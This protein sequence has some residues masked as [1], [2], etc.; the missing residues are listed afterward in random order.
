MTTN[1]LTI[2]PCT[3]STNKAKN[4]GALDWFRL[5]AA[6][7]VIA[8]H[9]SPLAEINKDAELILTGVAARTAVPFFFTVSGYF[10]ELSTVSGLKK[11]GA[12]TALFYGIAT[13][14]YLPLGTYSASFKEILF[15]GTYYHL[16]YFPACITGAMIV[17]KL[18]KLPMPAAFSIAAALYAIGL[19]G[20]SY[21]NLIS[22][23]EPLHRLYSEFSK[24]FSYTRNGIFTAP[25]FI[26][27][28]NI[29][30]G[31]P[32]IKHR[33]LTVSGLAVSVVLLTVERFLLR[34][35]A[36]APHDN[37]FISLIPSNFFLLLLLISINAKPRPFIRSMSMWIYI[38]HPL[39]I[40]YVRKLGIEDRLKTAFIVTLITIPCAA[41]NTVSAAKLKAVRKQ[42]DTKHT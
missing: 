33:V 36:L 38:I 34:G 2:Q 32:P 22:D 6:L 15:D 29:I 4:L 8:I 31:R 30:S 39:A 3:S 42:S 24:V 28:G 9:T 20:D 19:F 40:H 11:L 25:V 37:M 35:T 27:Y 26:L 23:I 14:L 16:W 13:A 12:K 21:Y 10:T 5:A 18:K 17:Y 41:L 7:L 1:S